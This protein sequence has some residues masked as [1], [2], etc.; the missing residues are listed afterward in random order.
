M[1]AVNGHMELMRKRRPLEDAFAAALAEDFED[2]VLS[3]DR[4]AS[5]A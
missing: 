2:R 4:A 3:F 5:P 1:Q